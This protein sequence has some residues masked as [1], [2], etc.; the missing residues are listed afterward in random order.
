MFS[1]RNE[2]EKQD[3]V[4]LKVISQDFMKLILKSHLYISHHCGSMDASNLPYF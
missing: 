1:L 4:Q 2:V 3:I